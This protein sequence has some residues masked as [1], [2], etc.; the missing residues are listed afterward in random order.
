[1]STTKLYSV[2]FG[3]RISITRHARERMAQRAIGDNVLVE[4]LERGRIRYK[5]SRRAWVAMA[6]DGRNDNLL[7]AAVSVEDELVVKT[8]MHRFRW[9]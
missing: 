4:L 8:V 6:F 1:M 5:D 7:C 3:K 9:E 2:R